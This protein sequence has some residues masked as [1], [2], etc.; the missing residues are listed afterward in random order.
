MADM[1]FIAVKFQ[2][3]IIKSCMAGASEQQQVLLF[4]VLRLYG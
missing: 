4:G 2:K 3:V 1:F